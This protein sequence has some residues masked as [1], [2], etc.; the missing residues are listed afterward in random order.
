MRADEAH[1]RVLE[2]RDAFGRPSAAAWSDEQTAAYEKAWGVWRTRAREAQLSV[3]AYA[4]QEGEPR[5]GV[6]V[7]VRGKARYPEPSA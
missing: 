6:E 2:L 5:F 4:V 1:S 3:S 7:A